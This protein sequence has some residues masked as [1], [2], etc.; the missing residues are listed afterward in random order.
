MYFTTGT[1]HFIIKRE[2]HCTAFQKENSAE[3]FGPLIYYV[4]V[5][6]RCSLFVCVS[7]YEQ[8]GG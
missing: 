5:N 1:C 3:H 7:E 2:K 6:I 8:G 4:G